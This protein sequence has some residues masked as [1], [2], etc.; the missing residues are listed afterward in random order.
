VIVPDTQ[1]PP[2]GR[3]VVGVNGSET[4]REALRWAA[5]AARLAR[6]ASPWSMPG[7]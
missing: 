4:S 2:T 6:I 3:V 7:S 1:R 5:D